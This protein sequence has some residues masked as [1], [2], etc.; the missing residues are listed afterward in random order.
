VQGDA[1]DTAQSGSAF[2]NLETAEVR[3][4]VPD[5]FRRRRD[6]I[7]E[8]ADIFI[9]LRV[10]AL[11]LDPAD[12]GLRPSERQPRVFGVVMDTGHPEGASTLVAL[13]DGTTSLYLSS[14]G[15]MI[16]GGEHPQVAAASIALVAGVEGVYDALGATWHENLPAAGNVMLRALAFGGP[17]LT[18][19]SEDDLGEDRHDLSPVFHLAHHVITELRLIDEAG[20]TPR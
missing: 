1:D 7:R 19:A 3:A 2:G 13:A 14:G 6:K 17:R 4:T 20:P 10:R 15:G 12:V 5:V 16:G 18:E 8:G 11:R 9:D